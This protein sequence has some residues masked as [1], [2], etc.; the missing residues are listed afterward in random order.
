[1]SLDVTELDVIQILD[2]RLVG[3]GA[4]GYGVPL[5]WISHASCLFV[6]V[7]LENSKRAVS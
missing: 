2:S 7:Y 5:D 6:L 1:M 4:G 3:T